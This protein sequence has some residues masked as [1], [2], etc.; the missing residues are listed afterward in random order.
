M[1]TARPVKWTEDEYLAREHRSPTK[2]EFFD[3]EVYPIPEATLRHNTI[4]ANMIIGMGGLVRGKPCRTFTS[5]QRI[6]MT[7]T[8]LYTYP[9]VGVVC[10]KPELHPKD[11]MTL[12]NPFILIEVLSKTTEL[13]DRGEK[14]EHYR[15][16]PSLKEIFLVST[17]E[18]RVDHHLR[19]DA[20]QWLLTTVR[21]GAVEVPS[22]S[23][24]VLLDDIY[25]KIDFTQGDE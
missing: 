16:I 1:Q 17:S 24:S 18:A 3:G 12:L 11:G 5:D 14:L 7:A 9:D 2:N 25:D 22:L 8:E 23:G 13:Y 15:N 10:D 6:H 20:G 4:A 21:E 19:L